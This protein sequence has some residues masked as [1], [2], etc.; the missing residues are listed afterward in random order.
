[1]DLEY[2]FNEYECAFCKSE[3]RHGATVCAHC[4]ATKGS[5]RDAKGG[6][7][8]LIIGGT[9]LAIFGFFGVM[10]SVVGPSVGSTRWQL[11]GY[12]VLDVLLYLAFF[13]GGIGA[14][15]FVTKQGMKPGWLRR[16]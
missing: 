15:Y 3:V 8:P 9:L 11:T 14:A 16:N 7:F 1:M 12:I 13:V 2:E 6:F 5:V 10:G 4:G